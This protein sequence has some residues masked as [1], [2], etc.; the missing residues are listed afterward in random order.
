MIKPKSG[1]FSF[2]DWDVTSIYYS[3]EETDENLLSVK[4]ESPKELDRFNGLRRTGEKINLNELIWHDFRDFDNAREIY[5]N[6]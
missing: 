1:Q 4:E 5:N 6:S 3:L 2:L